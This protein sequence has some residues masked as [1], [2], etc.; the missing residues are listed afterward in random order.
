MVEE[1]GTNKCLTFWLNDLD[2]DL[3]QGCEC[4]S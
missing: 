3:G 1:V 4:S 2:L